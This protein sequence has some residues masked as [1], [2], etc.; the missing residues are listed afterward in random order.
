MR[1]F[2]YSDAKSHKFWNIELTGTSFTVTY[3]R[4][5]TAGTSQTRTFADEAAARKE[6]DKLV[7]EKLNKGYVEQ[8]GAPPSA[9]SMREA[10]EAAIVA[11]LDDLASHMAYADWLHD[12]GDPRGDFIQAQLALGDPNRSAKERK[13]LEK[14]ETT[15]RE[16]HQRQWLGSLA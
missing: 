1:S 13:E 10:L 7:A 9:G 5:G 16:T 6:H 15:L 12:Q 3:G 2:T 4:Q 8:G 14:T 11:N